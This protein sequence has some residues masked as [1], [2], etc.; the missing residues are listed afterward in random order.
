MPDLAVFDPR[1]FMGLP[2]HITAM[3]G[4]DAL[5]HAMESFMSTYATAATDKENLASIKSIFKYL[6]R[7]YENGATDTEARN[8]MAL[9]SFNAGKAFSKTLLGW[10]HGISHQLGAFY[11]VPHGLGC[12]KALPHVLEFAIP[13][14]A[15]RLAIIADALEL[16]G[17][18]NEEKAYAVVEAVL[19]LCK[20]LDIEP[21]FEML[22]EEDVAV[23]A[24]NIVKEGN[25]GYPSH[26][27]F[28]SYQHL[29]QFLLERR[30][31]L[32]N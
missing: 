29:E 4:M 10:S 11:K 13:E 18:N 21:T 27:N 31:P 5:T 28:D 19:N 32:T 30:T 14:A 9:A 1:L 24:R 3:T 8:E 26:R 23:I 17:R 2:P 22:K 12:A 16:E 7:A 25:V 15:D 6:P 20:Q